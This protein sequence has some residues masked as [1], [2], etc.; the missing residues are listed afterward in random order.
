[1]LERVSIYAQILC[2]L[3]DIFN[4]LFLCCYVF[5]ILLSL[6]QYSFKDFLSLRSVLGCLQYAFWKTLMY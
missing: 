3:V 1:M 4:R 6:D 5:K 2:S